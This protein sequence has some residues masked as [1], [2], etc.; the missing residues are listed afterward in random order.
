MPVALETGWV[1]SAL[2]DELPGFELIW[3]RV[4]ARAGRTPRPLRDRMRELANR[5]TGAHVVQLRQDEVRWAYRVLWR[6]LGLDP[7][8]ERTPVER[9]MVER[10][11]HGGLRSHGLPEDAAV[12]ATLE[13]GVPIAVFDAAPIDGPLGLR[14]AVGGESLADDSGHALRAGE[15][16]IADGRRPVARLTGETAADCVAGK[17]T[18][19]MLVCAIAAAGVSRLALE[20]A[21][22]TAA[23]LLGAAGT[24]ETSS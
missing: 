10:L 9:L 11:R 4:A 1:D 12:V 6:R 3:T 5:I 22:W 19:A 18:T 24:L 7:D 15:V 13:T 8:S 23:E 20:E 2:A 14:P 16:V 17:Q 21:I